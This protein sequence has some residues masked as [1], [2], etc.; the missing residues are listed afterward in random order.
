MKFISNL[1]STLLRVTLVGVVLVAAIL[2]LLAITY[3]LSVFMVFVT[4]PLILYYGFQPDTVFK[5]VSLINF[6][7][8]LV[9]AIITALDIYWDY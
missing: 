9:T 1:L 5:I 4:T 6:I 7:L 2:I 8:F 3:Y